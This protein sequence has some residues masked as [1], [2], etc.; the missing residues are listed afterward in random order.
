MFYLCFT[1]FK[2]TGDLGDHFPTMVKVE[3][4][5]KELEFP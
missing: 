5:S 3:L 1:R 4:E 2:A